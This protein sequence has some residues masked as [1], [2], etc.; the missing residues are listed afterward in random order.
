MIFDL[1]RHRTKRSTFLNT[2]VKVCPQETIKEVIASHQAYYKL[3]VCQE[4]IW[5][6]FRIFFDRIPST[7]EYHRWVYTCQFESLCIADLARNFSNSQEHID[8]VHRRVTLRDE[9]LRGRG[10]ATVK[11]EP[12]DKIP[13]ITGPKEAQTEASTDTPAF[14]TSLPGSPSTPSDAPGVTEVVQELELPNLVPEQPVEMVVDFSITLMRPGYSELLNDPDDLEYND[15]TRKLQDQMQNVLQKLPGFKEIRILGISEAQEI[16]G[17]ISVRYTVVFETDPENADDNGIG[18]NDGTVIPSVET[19]LKLMIE[20]ALT[21]D[22]SLAKDLRFLRFDPEKIILPTLSPPTESSEEV[23]NLEPGAVTPGLTPST[24]VPII[25]I[26]EPNLEVTHTSVETENS[27][28]NTLD[29]SAGKDLMKHTTMK[30]TVLATATDNEWAHAESSTLFTTNVTLDESDLLSEHGFEPTNI[31]QTRETLINEPDVVEPIITH[32]TESILEDN[33]QLRRDFVPTMTPEENT[34]ETPNFM[35]TI[36]PYEQNLISSISEEKDIVS[37]LADLVDQLTT[38]PQ[39]ELPVT[40][41]EYGFI[42][43]AGNINEII[44][45]E[46][47][48]FPSTDEAFDFKGTVAMSITPILL[49]TATQH[50]PSQKELTDTYDSRMPVT[51]LSALTLQPPTEAIKDLNLEEETDILRHNEDLLLEEDVEDLQRGMEMNEIQPEAGTVTVHPEYTTFGLLSEDNK[52]VFEDGTE[53]KEFQPE[54]VTDSNDVLEP[55]NTTDVILSV[56]DNAYD[57]QSKE[58]TNKDFKPEEDTENGDFHPETATNIFVPPLEKIT[59]AED[60]KVEIDVNTSVLQPEEINNIDDFH[61]EEN[62]SP[63]VFQP[64]DITEFEDLHPQEVTDFIVSQSEEDTDYT[65]HQPVEVID[66]NIHEKITYTTVPPEEVSVVTDS[67]QHNI[68]Q[69]TPSLGQ[70]DETD[71]TPTLSAAE[72]TSAKP[73]PGFTATMSLGSVFTPEST[74]SEHM[75]HFEVITSTIL[76]ELPAET[77]VTM[78]ATSVGPTATEFVAPGTPSTTAAVLLTA[79]AGHP[80]AEATRSLKPEEVTSSLPILTTVRSYEPPDVF[81]VEEDEDS[82]IQTDSLV[83]EPDLPIDSGVQDIATE[84]DQI[85][86][87]STETIDMLDYGS[88]FPEEHPFETTVSPPLKYLTTPSMT[89]AS[90]GRELVV[91]FSLR[92]TNMMFS[93]DLFNKS[94]PE[95]KSLENKF[96]ELLLPYLQS[97]LTGFKQLEIL[98]FRNGSVVVNSKMRFAKSVPYNITQAVHCVLEEFCNAMFKRLNIEIDSGSLDVEPAD[99]ADPCKFLACNEFSSC[100]VNRWTKE[101][102]CLCDPGYIVADGLPCQSI[103]SLQPDYCRNG[104]QCEIIPGHGA[105]CRCPVGSHWHFRGEH[106]AELVSLPIDPLLFTA[107]FVGFFSFVFGAITFW[108]FIHRKCIR[109]RKTVSL[110]KTHSPFT[111]KSAVRVSPVFESDDGVLHSCSGVIAGSSELAEEDTLDS[112]EN[113][114]LII[115]APRRLHIAR[116]DKL[117]SEMLDTHHFTRNHETWRLRNENWTLCCL[118][119]T[120][121]TTTDSSSYEVTVL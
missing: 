28:E 53:I 48:V 81:S 38:I 110:V 44:S 2:G 43:P 19:N 4:A 112:V 92:V 86:V 31:N 18:Q 104:G 85:D 61:L 68:A 108:I 41:P 58:D 71:E 50:L 47:A 96:L 7:V 10:G 13:Q 32:V 78:E 84:L 98:N 56:V 91:F 88:G 24:E 118:R 93:D 64:K 95:Y 23:S 109:T 37:P 60:R 67:L 102:E 40:V 97:N 76:L 12:T 113:V 106:C 33:S 51:T 6:A 42:T 46:S 90:K 39:R 65:P 8:M 52:L 22:P 77:E 89:T 27:S 59:M 34:L 66:T 119:R 94:S 83:P 80:I 74:P 55:K 29:S 36:V 11:A 115:E 25:T 63:T 9:K 116:P 54:T 21:E 45:E 69:E 16:D 73:R 62:T 121:T 117:I 35:S 70:E 17:G 75:G 20:K 105:A 15:L 26:E 100:V 99:Q 30:T 107:C 1:E 120:T 79:S 111:F 57:L 14:I 49:T 3:R 114:H 82:A 103:C 72:P 87:V 101:A 5:E